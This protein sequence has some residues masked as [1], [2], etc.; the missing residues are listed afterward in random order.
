MF[1]D[2]KGTGSFSIPTIFGSLP[3]LFSYKICR[4]SIYL[5]GE[6]TQRK[7]VYLWKILWLI[8][9]LL[10][11]AFIILFISFYHGTKNDDA[12]LKIPLSTS[13]NPLHIRSV[14]TYNETYLKLCAPVVQCNPNE[15]YRSYNGSCNNLAIPTYGAAQTPYF[16][17]MNANYSDGINSF[18]TQKYGLPLPNSRKLQLDIFLNQEKRLID[19]NNLFIVPFG[20][21]IAH[22]ISSLPVKVLRDLNGQIVDCCPVSEMIKKYPSCIESVEVDNDDPVYGNHNKTCIGSIRSKTSYDF[23]CSLTPTTFFNKNTHFLDA[24][25]VYGFNDT[26]ANNLRS[27][28]SGMLRIS[29]RD[30]GQVFC[31]IVSIKSRPKITS[32]EIIEFETANTSNEGDISDSNQNMGLSVIQ[33]MVVRFHNFV[34]SNL[35]ILNPQWDD[36]TLYQESRRIVIAVIQ[37]I[38]YEDFLPIVIGEDYHTMYGFENQTVYDPTVNPS[39]SAEMASAA[40]RVLHNVVP[41]DFKLINENYTEESTF[42]ITDWMSKPNLLLVDDN[43]DKFIRGFLET[44]M[45]VSQPSYNFFISNYNF[46]F[47]F[48]PR[49]TGVDLLSFDIQRGR[50]TGMQPYNIMRHICGLPLASNFEDL[51]D[52]IHIKHIEKLKTHYQTVDDID[53]MVGLLLEKPQ[54]DAIVGPTARCIIADNFY[55]SKVGDRFFYD[56]TG[57]PGS[58][59]S[60]QINEIKKISLSNIICATSNV[61]HVQRDTFKRVDHD[62]FKYSKLL[63]KDEYNINFDPWIERIIQEEL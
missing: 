49:Y 54:D 60:E 14:A 2:Y 56:V 32:D 51:R 34:A 12:I 10:I 27:H 28:K 59:S 35:S 63:C 4:Y 13:S 6:K 23:G 45:R 62:L 57:Q 50:D 30:D 53:L 52:V 36:E 1:I 15:K 43:Y 8:C 20:Q 24:S 42:I 40:F 44:P 9:I 18:R 25:E 22:D 7:K 11:I 29:K 37:R 55:R 16:R 46:A 47:A 61:D 58:F 33:T 21:M 3:M 26:T 38:A 31:P 39:T 19:D 41:I 48:Q 17:L 5:M